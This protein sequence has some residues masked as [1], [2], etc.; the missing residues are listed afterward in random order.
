MT[1]RLIAVAMLL[2]ILSACDI[3]NDPVRLGKQ[4][5]S[6]A[7]AY[8]IEQQSDQDALDQEQQ[9][10]TQEQQDAITV[11]ERAQREAVTT[12]QIGRVAG[13]LGLSVIIMAI[14]VGVGVFIL[15]VGSSSAAAI[16]QN[17]KA[18]RETARALGEF[19]RAAQLHPGPTGIFPGLVLPAGVNVKVLMPGTNALLDSTNPPQLPTS[20]EQ[21]RY[22]ELSA[23]A[24]IAHGQVMAGSDQQLVMAQPGAHER[25]IVQAVPVRLEAHETV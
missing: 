3:A 2:V 13:W 1:R 18:I 7:Q 19:Q 9:R 8:A 14:G 17:A 20:R 10:Y 25:R 4:S 15:S 6:E 24:A 23:R 12:A 21:A 11:A 16:N 22:N 5:V